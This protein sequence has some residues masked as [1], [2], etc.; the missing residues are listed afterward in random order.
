MGGS[1]L[2]GVVALT[3]CL[4][5]VGVVKLLVGVVLLAGGFLGFAVDSFVWGFRVGVDSLGFFVRGVVFTCWSVLVGLVPHIESM[6]PQ[7]DEKLS[8]TELSF[9]WSSPVTDSSPF[10][11]CV[12]VLSSLLILPELPK[13]TWNIAIQN[14]TPTLQCTIIAC[15][16]HV[17]AQWIIDNNGCP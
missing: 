4:A 8:D 12:P 5:P 15:L 2:G 1:L 10:L 11:M 9:D 14:C 6:P 3:T 13:C 7:V 16:S 17:H